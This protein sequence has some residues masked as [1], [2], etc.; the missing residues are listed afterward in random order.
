MRGAQGIRFGLRVVNAKLVDEALGLTSVLL[1]TPT[2]DM[3]D[4]TDRITKDATK[5]A[6]VESEERVAYKQREARE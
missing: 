3:K 6:C 2:T 1:N 5:T 4:N